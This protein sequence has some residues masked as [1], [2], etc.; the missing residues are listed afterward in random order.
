VI[1]FFAKIFVNRHDKISFDIFMEII[2]RKKIK[3]SRIKN[4][5]QAIAETLE[6]RII[7]CLGSFTVRDKF[8][9]IEKMINNIHIFA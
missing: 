2:K 9:H 7:G 4:E 5:V 8:M 1:T 6:K 3:S